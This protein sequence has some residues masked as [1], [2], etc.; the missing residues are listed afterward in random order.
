[1]TFFPM[2]KVR[3]LCKVWLTAAILLLVC[4]PAAAQVTFTGRI[5]VNTVNSTVN[6]A[7]PAYYD[8][9]SRCQLRGI[10]RITAAA[11]VPASG[12]CHLR[13]NVSELHWRALATS[14]CKIA[15]PEKL[16][17]VQT[18]IPQG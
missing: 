9:N 8:A 3:Q 1:M 15:L 13:L 11:L 16:I 17:G 2:R 6:L 4:L 10:I 5:T 14:R 12:K 7:D 18:A